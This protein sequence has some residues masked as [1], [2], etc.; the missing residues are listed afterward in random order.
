MPTRSAFPT[1]SSALVELRDVNY[2]IIQLTKKVDEVIN[3]GNGG[4]GK[5]QDG[6][7]PEGANGSEIMSGASSGQTHRKPGSCGAAL[8]MI[9]HWHQ[10]TKR[11]WRREVGQIG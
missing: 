4:K 6:S 8:T 3:A 7:A 9:S 2:D 5:E 11:C 1:T 10:S